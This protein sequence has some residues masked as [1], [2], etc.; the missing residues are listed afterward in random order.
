MKI[1]LATKNE[2]KVSE[3]KDVLKAL[4]VEILTLDSFPHIDLPPETGTTFM[5][6][7]LIKARAVAEATGLAALADDSGLVVDALG[8]APG[9]YSARYAGEGA[10]D[11]ENYEKLLLELKRVDEW[12]RGARFV[13]VLAFV[14]PT[15][16]DAEASES[17][18]EARCEG[19]VARIGRGQNGFGYDPVFI[20]AF[21][22]GDGDRDSGTTMAELPREEKNLISHRAK[23]LKKFAAWAA[24]HLAEKV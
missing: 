18:F 10:T 6:N 12:E 23:A 9:V 3:L 11:E 22:N 15:E 13:C 17:T 16:G 20:P 2:K 4:D 5:E 19:A 7:A 14:V 1:V 21:I 24:L 8:G